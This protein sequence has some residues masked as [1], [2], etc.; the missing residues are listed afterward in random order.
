MVL[1]VE[2]KTYYG[3]FS[4]ANISNKR[5]IT[6][7]YK[8]EGRKASDFCEDINKTFLTLPQHAGMSHSQKSW[9]LWSV[10]V[11]G[12]FK[13]WQP[14]KFCLFCLQENSSSQKIYTVIFRLLPS[15]VLCFHCLPEQLKLVKYHVSMEWEQ[16][17]DFHDNYLQNMFILFKDV[18]ISRKC[19]P[20]SK[21]TVLGRSCK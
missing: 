17:L 3:P 18:F 11:L 13:I 10:A 21:Y 19:R 1:C 9:L 14:L 7:F 16:S 4:S 6:Y 20:V 5:P 8:Q 12:L 15:S 2:R